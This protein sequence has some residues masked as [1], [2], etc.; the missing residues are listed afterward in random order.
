[1]EWCPFK[2]L[3]NVELSCFSKASICVL[4]TMHSTTGLSGS[5]LSLSVC[6]ER[7]YTIQI[8]WKPLDAWHMSLQARL[9]TL[10]SHKLAKQATLDFQHLPAHCC[11]TKTLENKAKTIMFTNINFLKL[12]IQKNLNSYLFGSNRAL[13]EKE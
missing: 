8:A 7:T 10:S 6:T 1:M 4:C 11:Y 12:K 9:L 3:K 5:A 13:R 2:L